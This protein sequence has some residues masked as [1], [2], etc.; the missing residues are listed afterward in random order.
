MVP[1]TSQ[2][3]TLILKSFVKFFEYSAV[4]KAPPSTPAHPWLVPQNPWQRI[5]VDHAQ[6]GKYLLF[7]AIDAYSKWPEVFVVSYTTVQ[8]TGNR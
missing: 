5:H 7:I 4:D 3:L 8:Q 2:G 6:F 1:Y